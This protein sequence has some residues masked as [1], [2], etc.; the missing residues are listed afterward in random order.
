METGATISRVVNLSGW[1]LSASLQA[2]MQRARK[3]KARFD[4]VSATG[5]TID[6]FAST[7]SRDLVGLLVGALRSSPDRGAA[8]HT[9]QER[10]ELERVVRLLDE[11]I[12]LDRIIAAV[13]VALG[14]GAAPA[15]LARKEAR[16]LQDLFSAVVSQRRSTQDR[17]ADLHVDL[18]AIRSFRK[19]STHAGL[20]L[21][22]GRTTLRWYDVASGTSAEEVELGRQLLAR[23][24]QQSFG[25]VGSEE[26]LVIIAAERLADEVRDEMLDAA[27]RLRKRVALVY[28]QIGDAGQRMLGHGGSS[29]AVFLRLPNP[30]DAGEAAEFIGREH[31]FVVNGISIAEGET[32]D[33]NRSYGTS[34]SQGTSRGTSH[35]RSNGLQGSAFS[36][37]SAVGSSVS[38]SFE[39]G[40][41]TSTGSGGS[42][43]ATATTSAGRVHELVIQPEVFQQIPDD[44]MLVV[45]NGT[46]TIASCA[47]TI[48]W[49]G[50]V[51]PRPQ[52]TT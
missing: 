25:A 29:L 24:V 39:Q 13:D 34:T 41:S 9:Q 33:W 31:K 35:T 1:D 40:T 38:R 8:R 2:Q 27:Q 5:S 19:S 28:T 7:R 32:Q 10:Q 14:A 36:F 22:S 45:N 37:S 15:L 18:E 26:L 20:V 21:G 52:G 12:S 16:D 51:S 43:S 42:K 17:L 4:Q 23:A 3:N 47:N 49:S 30:R 44:L 11:P 6:L 48:R 50:Q 46:A